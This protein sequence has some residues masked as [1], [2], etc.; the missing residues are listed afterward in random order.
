MA[1]APNNSLVC[2]GSQDRTAKLWRLP[3]LVAVATFKGHK[4]GIWSVE[5]SPTDQVRAPHGR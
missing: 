2:T 4:R 5:F 3:D 1:V